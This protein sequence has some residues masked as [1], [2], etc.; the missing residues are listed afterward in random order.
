MIRKWKYFP[1]SQTCFVSVINFKIR[2]G[3]GLYCSKMHV[4]VIIFSVVQFLHVST[5][6]N[7]LI[8]GMHLL[9]SVCQWMHFYNWECTKRKT[10]FFFKCSY[11][12]TNELN[13]FQ[14]REELDSFEI[15]IVQLKL[16]HL[17]YSLYIQQPLRM[18]HTFKSFFFRNLN[19]LTKI[20]T[21]QALSR[22]SCTSTAWHFS[23][24]K[25]SKC[26][27]NYFN[28]GVS[29][30]FLHIFFDGVTAVLRL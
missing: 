23:R 6:C 29:M 7:N 21:R 24:A 4:F 12:G 27:R 14:K 13:S 5:G 30:S 8:H 1:D 19:Y 2:I 10:F 25:N 11:K 16:L 15:V 3:L 22:K 17:V 9:K 20:S 28:A 26:Y 18:W